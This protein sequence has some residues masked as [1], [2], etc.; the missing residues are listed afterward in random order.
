M[1]STVDGTL[2]YSGYAK[3]SSSVGN[4]NIADFFDPDGS[5]GI[6]AILLDTSATWCGAC[7]S[8]SGAMEQCFSADWSGLG[9]TAVVNLCDNGVTTAMAQ[10]WK[11]NYSLTDVNV[12]IDPNGSFFDSGTNGLPINV[13][14]DPRTMKIVDREN[15]SNGGCNSAVAPLAMQNKK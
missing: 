5:K 3:G 13:V 12:G 1:G 14:V 8:E 7:N 6:N 4:I 2:C 10:Q 11:T 9:V 15:G